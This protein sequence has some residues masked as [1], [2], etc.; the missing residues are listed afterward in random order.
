MKDERGEYEVGY[1]KPPRGNRF[2]AGQS[3]NPRGR[4]TGSRN[5]STLLEKAL[6]EAVFVNENGKRKKIS[7]REA[8]LKQLVNRAASGEPRSIQLLLAEVRIIEA[9]MESSASNGGSLEEADRQVL[10]HIFDR[11]QDSGGESGA[12][13]NGSSK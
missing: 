11:L 7:K 13:Q 8:V 10:Q 2:R 3:G 12:N 4:P 5:T 6:N 1:G 9:R